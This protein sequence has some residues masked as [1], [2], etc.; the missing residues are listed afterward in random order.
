MRYLRCTHSCEY[1]C[2]FRGY[3]FLRKDLY[4]GFR[5]FSFRRLSFSLLVHAQIDMKLYSQDIPHGGVE[6]PCLRKRYT[7][8]AALDTMYQIL[9][10][11][12][13]SHV[14]AVTV[15]RAKLE[16]LIPIQR[17]KHWKAA[18]QWRQTLGF[19]YL[20]MLQL[21]QIYGICCTHVAYTNEFG[22][23]SMALCF[24]TLTTKGCSLSVQFGGIKR[25]MYTEFL[26]EYGACCTQTVPGL[27]NS[28]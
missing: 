18:Y 14:L 20:T 7:L 17:W 21:L 28:R 22:H 11:K 6:V 27:G 5:S 2:I 3:K 25:Y 4:K 19:S 8:K 1:Y 9:H 26:P 13:Q 16:N 23:V 12:E 10:R 24:L 15:S